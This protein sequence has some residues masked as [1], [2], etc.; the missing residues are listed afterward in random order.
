MSYTDEKYYIY[1]Y[2]NSQLLT[3]QVVTIDLFFDR[4]LYL[5][6]EVE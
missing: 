2:E 4:K 1:I 5:E 6:I 3:R